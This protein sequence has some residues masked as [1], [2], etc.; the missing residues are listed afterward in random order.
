MDR[1]TVQIIGIDC[2]TQPQ[3]TGLARAKMAN[4]SVVVE[5]ARSGVAGMDRAAVV[6]S[7]LS[8]QRLPCW[9]LMLLWDG[10]SRWHWR[11][12]VMGQENL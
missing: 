6:G 10:P 2:A 8:S 3:K 4:G 12:R 11:W 1:G 5:E 7:W 9:P